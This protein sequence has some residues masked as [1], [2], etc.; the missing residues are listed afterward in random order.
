MV[1]IHLDISEV[2]DE[3]NLSEGQAE[4]L[5]SEII[6]RIVA[7]YSRKWE[8]LVNDNLKQLRKLYKSAM[9][10]NRDS[11]TT[12]EFGLAPGEDGLALAIEEGKPPFDI[13]EGFKNSPKRKTTLGGGWY[14]TIPFR[15]ATPTAVAESM[16]FQGKLPQEI[17][18][19][20]KSNGGSRVRRSQLPEQFAQLGRRKALMTDKGV[21]PEYVHKSPKF[22]GLVRMDISSTKNE[23]RGGYFTFRRVSNNSD[24]LSWI[25]PGFEAR[26]FMDKA[27]EASQI[28]T[29]ADM[30]IDNFLEQ[31]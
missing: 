10:I 5:G 24:V 12:V 13:K 11:S 1:P 2:V 25:H 9:Y 22:E 8:G 7:E 15:Y 4:A 31:L 27:L 3:F 16:S 18:N 17:F 6:D 21:I 14:L 29:V 19:I 26:L 20:V 30:A 28:E 23:N